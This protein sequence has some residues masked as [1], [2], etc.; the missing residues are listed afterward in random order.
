MQILYDSR[1]IKR[2]LKLEET[3]KP[4]GIYTWFEEQ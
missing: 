3:L 4:E 1:D 2:K